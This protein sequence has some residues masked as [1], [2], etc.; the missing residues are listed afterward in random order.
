MTFMIVTSPPS[1]TFLLYTYPLML[2][3]HPALFPSILLLPKVWFFPTFPRPTVPTR[4]SGDGC[5]PL[6]AFFTLACPHPLLPALPSFLLPHPVH[7]GS[8]VPHL[9][10]FCHLF[11]PVLPIFFGRLGLVT[12][13]CPHTFQFI[14]SSRTVVPRSL[15]FLLCMPA[16]APL[17]LTLHGVLPLPVPTFP[18]L[19][20]YLP[21][22]TNTFTCL[23]P[24]LT[25]FSFLPPHG[26][27]IL[28]LPF[29]LPHHPFACHLTVLGCVPVL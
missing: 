9:F 8:P 14:G 21:R 2:C 15:P 13:G 24:S 11:L 12:Q 28:V 18:V 6:P 10:A 3:C 7:M 20:S 5:Q 22:W 23:V 26:C 19:T 17:H 29:P 25:T 4:S 27:H 1:S 16:Y